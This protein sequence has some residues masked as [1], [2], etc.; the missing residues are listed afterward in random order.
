MVNMKI[1][2]SRDEWL[3]ERSGS[4]GGSDAAAV[5]GMNPWT[6]NVELWAEKTGRTIPEEISDSPYVKYG[7]DA[8]Q[9]LRELFRLDH[10]QYKVFYAENNL[11]TNEKYPWAHASLDGW[12]TDPEG[13]RGV[14]EIKTANISSPV[15]KRKWDNQIPDNYFCQVLFYMAVVEAD[16]AEVKGQLKWDN[17]E[18]ILLVTKHYHIERADVESDIDFL[19]QS[20]EKFWKEY[21]VKDV[22]PPLVLPNI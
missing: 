6:S 3:K 15:T 17:G 13:R 9:F 14:L 7:T 18:N 10:P 8:E 1:L 11:F 22:Q 2:K 20:C 21:V 5:V 12:L 16:F 19:M 4:I